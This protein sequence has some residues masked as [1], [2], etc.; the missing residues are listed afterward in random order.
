MKMQEGENTGGAIGSWE[1]QILVF[2][3]ILPTDQGFVKCNAVMY[4]I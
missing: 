4:A 3:L 1:K 2:L